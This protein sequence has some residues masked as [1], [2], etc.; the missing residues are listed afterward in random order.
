M[1]QMYGDSVSILSW[2]STNDVSLH[3][4][5][6]CADT[7]VCGANPEIVV[8]ARM[9]V[10]HRLAAP[11]PAGNCS[12]GTFSGAKCN[13]DSNNREAVC[14]GVEPTHLVLVDL[15]ILDPVPLSSWRL[16][17]SHSQAQDSGLGEVTRPLLLHQEQVAGAWWG[18]DA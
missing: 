7:V 6:G 14:E 2:P 11:W 18:A 8:T 12:S 9:S 1:R 10:L 4:A 3:P 5:D 15:P 13:V 17:C 16:P